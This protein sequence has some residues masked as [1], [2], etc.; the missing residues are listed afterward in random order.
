[1]TVDSS[2]KINNKDALL[3]AL[4]QNWESARYHE[5]ARWKY[6]YAYYAAFGAMLLYLFSNENSIFNDTQDIFFA[7]VLFLFLALAGVVSLKH[8]L[9]ANMEY[10]NHIRAIEFISKELNLNVGIKEYRIC[11]EEGKEDINE[12]RYAYM[13]LP[14]LLNIRRGIFFRFM[15]NLVMSFSFGISIFFI[16]LLILSLSYSGLKSPIASNCLVY[17]ILTSMIL[18]IIIFCYFH[19]YW[20][21]I[22]RAAKKELKSRDP[23]N[24]SSIKDTK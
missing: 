8:L 12:S 14:L 16:F 20:A 11:K 3:K 7:A 1:M 9:H 10:K 19:S 21:R 5:S 22:E 24:F 13:A 23:D 18:V 4:D 6:T 15:T 17:P 2:K